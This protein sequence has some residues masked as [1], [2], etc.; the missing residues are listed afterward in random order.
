MMQSQMHPHRIVT[1]TQPPRQRATEG[2]A[3]VG[4]RPRGHVQQG[5]APLPIDAARGHGV[6]DE[7][8]HVVRAVCGDQFL[9]GLMQL[10]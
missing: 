5:R 4:T 3:V 10:P 8:A 2:R 9:D 6:R 7:I 1:R